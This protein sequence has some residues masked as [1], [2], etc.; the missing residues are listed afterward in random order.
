MVMMSPGVGHHDSEHC[1]G[2]YIVGLLDR[3]HT[4][5]NSCDTM[6]LATAKDGVPLRISSAAYNSSDDHPD[7]RRCDGCGIPRDNGDHPSLCPICLAGQRHSTTPNVLSCNMI[8]GMVTIHD[9][10][11]HTENQT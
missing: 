11:D 4:Y 10:G 8:E 5:E 6:T 1:L 2:C 9:D 3:I 7:L